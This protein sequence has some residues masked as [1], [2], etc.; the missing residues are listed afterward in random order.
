MWPAVN[1]GQERTKLKLRSS[2]QTVLYQVRKITEAYQLNVK[3]YISPLGTVLT[4]AVLHTCAQ[5]TVHVY[6]VR[7]DISGFGGCQS[8]QLASSRNR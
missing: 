1:A 5:I 7:Q 4:Q 8:S 6:S 3:G 2:I